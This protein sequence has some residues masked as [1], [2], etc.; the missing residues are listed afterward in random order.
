MIFRRKSKPSSLPVTTNPNPITSTDEYT[1]K[2][3]HAYLKEKE[4]IFR[5]II[6]FTEFIIIYTVIQMNFWGAE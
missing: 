6:D 1:V 5:T 4:D 3:V 2:F